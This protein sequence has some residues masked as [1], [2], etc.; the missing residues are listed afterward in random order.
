[1]G[2]SCAFSVAWFNFVPHVA[3]VWRVCGVCVVCVWRVCGVCVA[4]VWRV[5]CLPFPAA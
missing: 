1:M 5:S 4:Y 2:L 3:C